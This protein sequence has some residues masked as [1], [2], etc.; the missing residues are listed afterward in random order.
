M[1][2]GLARIQTARL[3]PP[4]SRRD[5]H[6]S[7]MP[8]LTREVRTCC[9]STSCRTCPRSRSTFMWHRLSLNSICPNVSF[10]RRLLRPSAYRVISG[11]QRVLVRVQS[12]L[13]LGDALVSLGDDGVEVVSCSLTRPSTSSVF[14]AASTRA[15]ASTEGEARRLAAAASPSAAPASLAT[16][17]RL[18]GR[19]GRRA[20]RRRG[21]RRTAPRQGRAG[22]CGACKRMGRGRPTS[23]SRRLRTQRR[24]CRACWRACGRRRGAA[25]RRGAWRRCAPPLSAGREGARWQRGRWQAMKPTP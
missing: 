2:H 6:I 1:R 3:A 18:A 14:E 15:G 11:S 17:S 9:R 12:R 16:G 20:R 13:E 25:C 23:C 7:H 19:R 8:R 21:R 22:M 24:A 4:A 10:G 5:P